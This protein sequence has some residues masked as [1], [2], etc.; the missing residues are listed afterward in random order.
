MSNQEYFKIE[1]AYEYNLKHISLD[2]PKKQITIFTGVSGSGKSALVLDTIAA[3]SR[4]ELNETFPSFVQQYLPKYGRP[5]VDRIGN[6]PVAI[7]ID[8]RKP[9]PSARSTVGTY[10]DIYSRL[11]VIRD[12]P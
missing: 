8:Q 4:R 2:I 5:H 12:I 11:L 10:T 6:L 9:A 7:V 1:G 3:S